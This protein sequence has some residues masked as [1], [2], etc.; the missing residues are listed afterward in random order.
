[1][2]NHNIYDYGLSHQITEHLWNIL[3]RFICYDVSASYIHFSIEVVVELA[4]MLKDN[5][6]LSYLLSI[7]FMA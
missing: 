6:L 4:I 3:L 7:V 2:R 1:M 5:G